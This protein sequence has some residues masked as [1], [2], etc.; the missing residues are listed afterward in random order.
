MFNDMLPGIGP[1]FNNI[2]NSRMWWFRYWWLKN[3]LIEKENTT[4]TVVGIM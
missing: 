1:Y 3:S 2:M 4:H